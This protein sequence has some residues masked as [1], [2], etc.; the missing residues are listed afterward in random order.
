MAVELQRCHFGLYTVNFRPVK[1]PQAVRVVYI[2][3]KCIILRGK[4]KEIIRQ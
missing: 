4:E 2:L 3:F 1:S